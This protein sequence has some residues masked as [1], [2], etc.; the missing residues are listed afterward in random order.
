MVLGFGFWR[1]VCCGAGGGIIGVG[2]TKELQDGRF[3][4]MLRC[5]SGGPSLPQRGSD[6]T[7]SEQ[8]R[9]VYDAF[10]A[11]KRTARS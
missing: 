6:G 4:L 8:P 10:G 11:W 5:R 2:L 3:A 1:A 7:E 9:I